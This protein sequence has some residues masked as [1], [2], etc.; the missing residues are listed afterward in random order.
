MR[1]PRV[2]QWLAK[3]AV[4]YVY[5]PAVPI[6]DFDTQASMR[7][8]ARL[9]TP[10]NNEKVQEFALAMIDGVDFVAPI[11]YRPNGKDILIS[12]NHRI[13]AAI[14]AE[15][16]TLD[17]YRVKTEDKFIID[18]LTRSANTIEGDRPSRKESIAQAVFL[19]EN[20]K[21]TATAA[22]KQFHIPV[23]SVHKA[24][25]TSATR[26]RLAAVGDDPEALPEAHLDA[27]NA[28]KSDAVLRPAAELIRRANLPVDA[29]KSFIAEIRQT[30]NEAAALRVVQQWKT[31]PDVTDRIAKYK[32]GAEKRPVRGGD[33]AT[34]LLGLFGAIA[35]AVAGK[36]SL[37]DLN[38]T[39]PKE[40]ER[41]KQ[42]WLE[43]RAAVQ[44]ILK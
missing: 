5:I 35:N 9:S 17:T 39:S 37:D 41:V 21:S 29:A 24:M 15:K 38:V 6:E 32:G 11:S 26:K 12:G 31:R 7:N 13:H 10:L 42:A 27:L 22:A 14:T 34:K 20:R 16:K 19:V 18:R 25:R 30:A 23:E 43:C 40:K 3:E 33:G 44:T 36:K 8:Q 2:E 4:E 1:D 28:I